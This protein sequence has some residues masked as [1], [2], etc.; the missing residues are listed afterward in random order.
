MRL[1]FNELLEA[2][3]ITPYHLHKQSDGRISLSTA[4]RLARQ[5]GHVALFDAQVLE[6][7]CDVL[8]VEP[9]DLFERDKPK[10]TRKRS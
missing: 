3:G 8:G 2:A 5:N 10:A 4:Y 6:A 7:L 9:G 1:R